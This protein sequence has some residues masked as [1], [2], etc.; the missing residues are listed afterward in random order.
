MR[1]C[2]LCDQWMRAEDGVFRCRC[3]HEE[4]DDRPQPDPRRTRCE[5]EG[6]RTKWET[7]VTSERYPGGRHLC[8]RHYRELV[9]EEDGE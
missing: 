5:E 9:L 4:P 1:V 8:P 3:G 2:L 7:F 6:C